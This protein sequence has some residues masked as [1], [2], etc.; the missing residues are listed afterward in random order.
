MGGAW[1]LS[2]S[3]LVI[4]IIIEE[5]HKNHKTVNTSNNMHTKMSKNVKIIN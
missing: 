2:N 5:K 3:N 4:I 1:Y